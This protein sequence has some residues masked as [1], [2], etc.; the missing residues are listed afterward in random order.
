MAVD[1]SVYNEIA[2]NNNILA[3]CVSNAYTPCYVAGVSS[4][5]SAAS[6]INNTGQVLLSASYVARIACDLIAQPWCC[7]YWS[8]IPTLPSVTG[9]LFVC[10]V[11]QGYGNICC[12]WTVPAGAQFLRF[13]MWGAGAGSNPMC[14]CGMSIFGSSGAYASVII[15]AVPGCQYTICAGCALCGA[16]TQQCGSG[17]SSYVLGYGLSGVCADGGEHSAFC[18]MKREKAVN[19]VDNPDFAS[20]CVILPNP[21]WSCNSI[22]KIVSAG[23]CMCSNG[24]FCFDS[25][26][27]CN[28]MGCHPFITSCK[29]FSGSV[30]NA[31]RCCHFVIGTPGVWT[32]LHCVATGFL[33]G[34]ITPPVTCITCCCSQTLAGGSIG[35]IYTCSGYSLGYGAIP[36]CRSDNAPGRG[37]FGSMASGGQFQCGFPGTGGAVCVQYL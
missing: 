10:D 33:F 13:Q 24:G 4:G 28:T 7:C 29:M 6:T 27:C 9:G 34:F 14:C 8:A 23:Y 35:A 37:G 21:N 19:G 26:A 3:Q 1:V 11:A 32:A 18:W 22:G 25:A 36:C 5:V 12:A 15:P 17:C 20:L 31:T 30:T 16:I 2:K